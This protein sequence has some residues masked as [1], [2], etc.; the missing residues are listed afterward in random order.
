MSYFVYFGHFYQL[1]NVDYGCRSTLEIVSQSFAQ[2]ILQNPQALLDYHPDAVF[3]MLNPGASHPRDGLEP[4]DSIN[5]IQV[6]HDARSHLVPTCPDRTQRQLEKVMRERSFNH[7]RVLNLFDLREKDSSA[8]A[9]WI[10]ADLEQEISFPL[11]MRPYSIFSD[12]RRD[13]LRRR[14][15]MNDPR[16]AITAWGVSP[17]FDPFYIKCY[18]I[19][20]EEGLQVHGWPSPGQAPKKLPNHVLRRFYHPLLKKGWITHITDNWPTA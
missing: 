7:V 18:C 13:E 1:H 16:V 3:V 5:A 20:R 12:E 9:K 14:L 8:L 17:S 6:D 4:S 19:L 2:H 10:K 11:S 15:N